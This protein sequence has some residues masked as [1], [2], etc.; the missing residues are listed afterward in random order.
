MPDQATIGAYGTGGHP[1]VSGADVLD[2]AA[3]APAAGYTHT[4]QMDLGSIPA[5]YNPHAQVTNAD[6]LMVWEDNVRM[7][8]RFENQQTSPAGV[9]ATPGSFWWDAAQRRLFLH[10]AD[11]S[12]PRTNGRVYEASVRTLALHGGQDFLVEDV[13]AEKAY[14]KTP[15]GQQGYAILGYRGGTYRRCIGR[16]AWNHALGVANEEPG[17][18]LLFDACLGEDCENLTASA[19]ATIFVAYKSG[20]AAPARVVFRGCVARQKA[21]DGSI[22]DIG[23]F[24]HGESIDAV[25]DSVQAEHVFYGVQTFHDPTGTTILTG[26]HRFVNCRI[27]VLANGAHTPIAQVTARNCDYGVEAAAP[28]LTVEGLKAVD[29]GAGVAFFQPGGTVTVRTSVIARSTPPAHA[30]DGYGLYTSPEGATTRGSLDRVVFY[31]LGSAIFGQPV[32]SDRNTFFGCTRIASDSGIG[33]G[34]FTTLAD[35]QAASQLDLHSVA[36]DPGYDPAFFAVRINA[37]PPDA[38]DDVY[39]LGQAAE[40]DV[41]ANDGDADGDDLRLL[42]VASPG[43]GSAALTTDGLRIAYTP[44][45]GFDGND[46]FAYTLTDGLRS[47]TALVRLVN[48]APLPAEDIFHLPAGAPV[49]LLDVLANDQDPDGDPLILVA[50][51]PARVGTVAIQDA[52]LAYT[53]APAYGSDDCLYTVGDGY[54][55]T[56]TVQVSLFAAAWDAWQFANFGPETNDPARAGDQADPDEDLL[57]N[58]L[59]YAMGSDPRVANPPGFPDLDVDDQGPVFR[60]IRRPDRPDLS[61]TVQGNERADRPQDWVDLAESRN[62]DPVHSLQPGVVA[63][64]P[65]A[66]PSNTVSVRTG[67]LPDDQ[68]IL[69]LKIAR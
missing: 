44:G 33:P 24:A 46:S 41:L 27:G 15:A 56:A 61:Y 8:G 37:H 43:N 31:R 9:E 12:D 35:W 40:L 17:G 4:Y 2:P 63:A 50:V 16:Q 28:G 68:L 6:V 58:L 26:A 13:I 42:A 53:P 60:F 20:L 11:H 49:T 5:T 39:H 54:G 57:P 32:A 23:F 67:D 29:C 10:P 21:L 38:R 48:T 18:E 30:F 65:G 47:N 3:F 36:D 14:A 34:Y 59:E 19:P 7:G 64:D 62:G 1:I 66:G 22:Q 25:F 69:R 45:P 55:A 52:S 51:T